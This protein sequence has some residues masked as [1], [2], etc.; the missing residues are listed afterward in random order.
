MG[1][2]MTSRSGAAKK[3]QKSIKSGDTVV[4]SVVGLAYADRQ[5]KKKQE[6]EQND[7]QI[8]K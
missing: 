3:V 7:L 4:P 6:Q 2:I 1:G 8:P 5:K